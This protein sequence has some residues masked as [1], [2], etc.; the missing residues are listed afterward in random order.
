MKVSPFVDSLNNED[1][2]IQIS[3][4]KKGQFIKLIDVIFSTYRIE[5]EWILQFQGRGV[6]CVS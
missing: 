4:Q 5:Q 3:V 6:C 1:E 2:K